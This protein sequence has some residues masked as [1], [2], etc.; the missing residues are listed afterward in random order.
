MDAVKLALAGES[1]KSPKCPAAPDQP[2]SRHIMNMRAQLFHVPRNAPRRVAEAASARVAGR[3]RLLLLGIVIVLGAGWLMV[4]RSERAS[5][6]AG[7]ADNSTTN[8]AD[9]LP[10][11]DAVDLACES[12]AGEEDPGAALELMATSAGAARRSGPIKPAG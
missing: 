4:G 3:G 11:T 8:S 12:V 6:A 1:P 10:S 9:T 2:P 5:M 7:R